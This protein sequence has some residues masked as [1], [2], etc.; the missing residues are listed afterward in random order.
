MAEL[1]L[2]NKQISSVF[3]LLG[4]KENHISCSVA[5]ALSKCQELLK[6]F[7]KQT[8][9]VSEFDIENVAIR[10]QDY[11][12]SQGGFTDIEIICEPLFYII[13][14]A[15]RGWILPGIEQLEKYA[16]RQR[17]FNSPSEVKKI[18]AMSECSKDFAKHNLQVKNIEGVDILH[19]SWKEIYEFSK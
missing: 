12:D 19:F 9:D 2:H 4:D 7:I 5:W 3:Q 8:I 6:E 17:F 13:I 14:E 16:N 11:D 18:I 1:L 10:L 15:K